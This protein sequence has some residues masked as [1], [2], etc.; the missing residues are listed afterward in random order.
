MKQNPLDRLRKR[1]LRAGDVL[2]EEGDEGDFAYILEEGAIEI[3]S[4]IHDKLVTLTTL[5]P[6]SLFGEL[7]LIDGRSRSAKAIAKTDVILTIITPE[8]VEHR[9]ASADPVVRMLL[10][11]VT[12][13]FR[14]EA[15]RSRPHIDM[16]TER[17]QQL[18]AAPSQLPIEEQIA[19]AVDL[20][21]MESELQEALA[22]DQFYLLYQPIINLQTG[23]V[24]GFEALIRWQSPQRGYVTPST[25]MPL[26]ELTSL[27]VPIGEWV[28]QAGCQALRQMQTLSQQTPFMSFNVASRQIEET[29]FMPFVMDVI[30]RTALNPAHVKLEVLERSL[31]DSQT[32]LDWI[33]TCRRQRVLLALDDFGTGYSSLEYLSDYEFDTLK[34]DKSFIDRVDSDDRC[35]SICQSIIQLSMNLGMTTVAEGIERFTQAET[36]RTMGCVMGQGYLFAKPVPLDQALGILQ[37]GSLWPAIAPAS[38]TATASD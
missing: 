36:L 31:F 5:Y 37:A 17:L 14:A 35:R 30:H 1:T 13:Y 25:F 33:Q 4:V 7:A 38:P 9:L 11:S 29:S 18:G 22:N 10:L 15:S 27:V 6:G 12:R 16:Q 19:S 23:S 34:I 24:A 3:Q 28:I 2:F 21:R 32:T 26:A 20:I 8:Q